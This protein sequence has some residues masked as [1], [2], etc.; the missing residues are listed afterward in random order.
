MIRS[1]ARLARR[2]RRAARSERGNASVEF[3]FL[4]P[5]FVTLLISAIESGL[6][7]MRYVWLDRALDI[8]VRELRLGLLPIDDAN[9]QANHDSVK[10]AIC[11]RGELLLPDCEDT[12]HLELIRVDTTTWNVPDPNTTCVDR[13]SAVNPPLTFQG[14]AQNEMMIIRACYIVDPLV[15][16]IG[17]GARFQKDPT[18]G[19]ALI[20]S[21]AFVNEP[22]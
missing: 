12:L 5:L 21:S 2:T 18:G 20:V 16:D 17:L 11:T 1:L 8:T 3:V 19:V 22:D 13:A 7:T 10:N 6:M 15:P 9:A 14:R 4:F